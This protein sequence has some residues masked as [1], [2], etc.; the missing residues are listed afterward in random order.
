M[1][2]ATLLIEIEDLR[3]RL[4]EAAGRTIAFE[5]EQRSC[6]E[7]LAAR[8]QAG[9]D[10]GRMT[11]RLQTCQA[12]LA[13]AR[14]SHRSL[15]AAAEQAN[16]SLTGS[17][18]KAILVERDLVQAS[19][20]RRA[21]ESSAEALATQWSAA[22]LDLPPSQ[23]VI[24]AARLTILST[25]GRLDDLALRQ[26]DLGR[27][28]EA[29]LL[30]QE[31]DEIR[32]AMV[33]AG[34]E[35]ALADAAAH[36][37]TLKDELKAARAA[38]KLSSSARSA[39]N[40][41]T[42]SLK[43]EAAEFST[44][45]LVPLNRVI[46]DFNEAMLSTPSE[47]IRF[48]AEHRVDATRFEMMLHYRDRIEN[49]TFDTGLPPQLVLSEGQLAAN[50]FSI[51]CAASTAYPWSRWRALLLDDPLQHNDIIHTAAF[52]DVMR[53]MV[54]QEGYQLIMSSHDRA[55][56]DFIT[57]KF[58]AA[59]L[60]CSTITLTAPSA[61][62]VQFDDPVENRAATRVRRQEIDQSV[63]RAG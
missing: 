9:V 10:L 20:V 38:H 7:R 32:A 40:K 52:V 60:P 58:D 48:N 35:A 29:S 36:E 24:E 47:T 62:G 46:D 6:S 39:V 49:A 63:N 21:A 3:R 61:D 34:S 27:D 5:T 28:N 1:Q 56:T 54:E 30:Q 26:K 17:R 22:G 41:F 13:S 43:K 15:L 25:L 50:G 2:H 33:S 44:Q 53:N 14:D 11:I 59:G 23:G 4:T 42:D 45:F 55:E 51:L 31:V 8:S 12:H 57:R 19:E 37:S 18:A 16:T